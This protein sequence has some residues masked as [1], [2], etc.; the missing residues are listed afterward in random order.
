MAAPQGEVHLIK[1]GTGQSV[2]AL[3]VFGKHEVGALAFSSD[4]RHLAVGSGLPRD[5]R[6]PKGV[7]AIW[8]VA[9]RER[10]RELRSPFPLNVRFEDLAFSP[11]G[12]TLAARHGGRR[13][14]FWQPASGL[15]IDEASIQRAKPMAFSREGQFLI[16]V[17]DPAERPRGF[18]GSRIDFMEA[19][20]GGVFQSWD[21]PHRTSAFALAPDGRLLALALKD[22]RQVLLVALPTDSADES[23]TD[24]VLADAV[25]KLAA[26]DAKTGR[27]AMAV[28]LAA[29]DRSVRVLASQ[30]TPAGKTEEFHQRI[31]RLV[32]DLDDDNFFVREKATEALAALGPD[33]APALTAALD[34]Q[35]PL[36][37]DWRIRQALKFTNDYAGKLRGQSL[38]RIRAIEILE[39]TGT[40]EAEALLISLA[41]TTQS[42]REA[43]VIRL[44]LKRIQSSSAGR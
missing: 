11:D 39:R 16:L 10:I 21:I 27:R 37:A 13:I 33:A 9:T 1:I 24:S 4:G 25:E 20:T 19:A 43:A 7:V 40:A 36:E 6:A 29:E 23:P 28:L 38:R 35:P 15:R 44:A 30:L 12:G 26:E 17:G 42:P 2:P 22:S 5:Q 31:Q 18:T 8:D 41:K 14:E 3:T 34:A 32:R